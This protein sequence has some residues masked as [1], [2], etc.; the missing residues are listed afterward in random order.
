VNHTLPTRLVVTAF[1]VMT[2]VAARAEAAGEQAAERPNFVFLVADDLGWA[3]V[4]FHGG[5][6]A[7]PAIDR[8]AQEGVR[9]ERFY[10]CPVCSPTRAGLMTGRWP[11]R[12]GI[13]RTVIPPWR[14]WGLPPGKK[15]LAE[16]VAEAGYRRRAILGKW[17]LGHSDRKYH[18]LNQGF[19]YFYGHYNGA[20]DYWTHEREGEVDWHRNFETVREEGYSTDLI[21]AEAVR[22]IDESPADE[23]FF[24]YVPF[25]AVH[26]PFQA[27]EEDIERFAQIKKRRRRIYAAMVVA[28]DRAVNAILE[29]LDRRGLADETFVLFFSDNG[30]VRGVADNGPLRAGKATVYEGGIR[31]AAAARWP[32]GGI[33]GGGSI[34]GPI[35][36]VDV[37]PTVKRI[38]GLSGA[39]D[40]NPLDGVDVLDVL[41]GQAEPPSRDWFSY[42]SMADP[43]EHIS[44]IS[45]RH[46]LNVHG[47]SVLD[48]APPGEH[49]LELFDL[50][51]D[52]YE[53][54]NLVDAHPD[55][56][57]PML[58]K[59]RAFRRWK[60]DGVGPYAEGREGFQAP[61]DWVITP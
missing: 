12:V 59:L 23:P 27:H 46:K 54:H 53:K 32:G 26:S 37:Y 29:A 22:F 18:P 36:Y 10:V 5:R 45:G 20:I 43:V 38:V 44:L 33:R 31:V 56:V 34:D 9:L 15:T 60:I 16:L 13:M 25:N 40:P 28:L 42:L 55:L 24:L 6:I 49:Q 3:D 35:G 7:T 39:A 2:A 57:G 1:F 58:D 52:P 61:K 8:I 30:G 51:Q 41:R 21:G 17:H 19:T 48:D 50:E 11:L 47:P 14:R 4:G